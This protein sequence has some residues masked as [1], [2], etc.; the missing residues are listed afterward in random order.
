[1]NKKKFIITIT[2]C[3]AFFF[4]IA[5]G[6]RGCNEKKY[7]QAQEYFES[8]HYI[9]AQ[10][11]Y[12]SLGEY[13]NSKELSDD[14]AKGSENKKTY[15]EALK[16]AKSESYDDA[17]EKLRGIAEFEDSEEQII[18]ITY[19]AGCKYFNDG[20]FETARKYFLQIEDYED[21]EEYINKIKIELAGTS[22]R[23]AYNQAID[24]YNDG[25][26]ENALRLFED[27]GSYEDCEEYAQRIK[28]AHNIAGG[29]GYSLALTSDGHVKSA[30]NNNQGQCEVESWED[31]ISIDGY[32]ECTIG[33]K[34]DGT[35]EVTGKLSQNQKEKISEW[36]HIVDVA[37][38]EL[39]VV[40][41]RSDGTVLAEGHNGN[42]QCNLDEWQAHEVVDIDAGWSF[43]VGLT[44]SGEL[45]FAGKADKLKSDYEKDKDAW[46][47]VIKIAAS[48]GES[49]DNPNIQRG[50]GH[51]VG[52]KSG[53]T[54]VVIGDD[55]WKQK[56]VDDEQWEDI[57]DIAAGDWYTVARRADGTILITGENKPR[58]HYI[59]QEK[60]DEWKELKIKEIAA[61][62]GQTIIMTEDGTVDSMGF[63]EE[64]QLL[65]I[66]GE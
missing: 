25:S 9:E 64:G 53:K 65:T 23:A 29:V 66:G 38:G 28:L 42:G 5:V 4:L 51:V 34:K 39:F 18:K 17:I 15:E 16:D 36:N 50:G 22:A 59:E 60:M 2:T 14:A 48:G 3:Y 58:T 41:L 7:L 26:Y 10:E 37:A 35:V 45:L 62:Y 63:S 19:E 49:G 11:I 43:T 12:D 33:L 20:E 32:G 13:R 24:Y 46:K 61:G 54:V 57:V 47:D 40:A 30:G 52:L 21:S 27:L 8:G 1:M 31:I 6:I 55:E 56:Q 44:D